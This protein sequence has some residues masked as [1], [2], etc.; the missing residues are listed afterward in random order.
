MRQ[1]QILSTTD[2]H[3]R[4]LRFGQNQPLAFNNLQ[5]QLKYA[6]KNS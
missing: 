4:R 2:L 5:V 3:L 6:K 1:K